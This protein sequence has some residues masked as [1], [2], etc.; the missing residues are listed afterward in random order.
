[1]SDKETVSLILENR[2]IFL[3]FINSIFGYITYRYGK[4][5]GYNGILS[6]L[7]GFIFGVGT[8][9]LFFFYKILK[10]FLKIF[11]NFIIN[12][13]ARAVQ[14]SM[15]GICYKCR[16]KVAHLATKCPHCHTDLPG[17]LMSWSK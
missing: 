10:F 16:K 13:D 15:L 2:Y 9:G 1:M 12:T 5:R 11:V 7:P 17:N 3:F 6:F 8:L 4:K 14:Q